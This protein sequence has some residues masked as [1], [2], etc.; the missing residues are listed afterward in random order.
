MHSTSTL[1]I[2]NKDI[3]QEKPPQGIRLEC[4]G[5]ILI[6]WIKSIFDISNRLNE[7]DQ[8]LV[9]RDTSLSVPEILCVRVT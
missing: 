4:T 1:K 9:A 6:C 5:N 8:I 2:K 3:I 7:N